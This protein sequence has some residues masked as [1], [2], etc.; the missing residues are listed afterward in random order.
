MGKKNDGKQRSI[1]VI[2]SKRNILK[3]LTILV[4]KTYLK[5]KNILLK[6]TLLNAHMKRLVNKKTNFMQVGFNMLDVNVLTLKL[7][8]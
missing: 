4:S 3:G 2:E 8:F 1:R 5:D 6:S 7:N